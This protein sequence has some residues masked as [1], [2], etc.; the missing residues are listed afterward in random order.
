MAARRGA[1]QSDIQRKKGERERE[2][3]GENGKRESEREKGGKR[4][5]R[6][7]ERARTRRPA[8]IY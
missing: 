4:I 8:I 7:R 3:D 1:E 5:E 6:G 2:K